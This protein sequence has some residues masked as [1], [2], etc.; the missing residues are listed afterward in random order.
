MTKTQKSWAWRSLYICLI[1][2]R[3]HAESLIYINFKFNFLTKYHSLILNCWRIL[4]FSSRRFTR[5]K[6]YKAWAS[7]LYQTYN[8]SP[9]ARV[10]ISDTT[11]PLMLYLIYYLQLVMLKCGTLGSKDYFC[12]YLR[13][14][15][16]KNP[17]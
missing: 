2:C 16:C 15:T 12:E 10:C 14:L 9:S 6:L 1:W 3:N 17:S 7:V 5:H 4:M 11:R 13:K 8:L